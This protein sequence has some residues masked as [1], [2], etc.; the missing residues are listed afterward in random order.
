MMI[1]RKFQLQAEADVV[2]ARMRPGPW[3]SI[4]GACMQAWLGGMICSRSGAMCGGLEA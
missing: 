1:P 4:G 3:C 2:E